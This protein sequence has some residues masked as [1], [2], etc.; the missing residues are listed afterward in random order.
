[1]LIGLWGCGN[2]GAP[3]VF[4]SEYVL[5]GGEVKQNFVTLN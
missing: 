3:A 1:M 2:L 4:D 5:S